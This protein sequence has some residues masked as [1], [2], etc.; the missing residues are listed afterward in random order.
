MIHVEW[1]KSTFKDKAVWV[2]LGLVEIEVA[3]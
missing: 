3:N 1:I 2:K